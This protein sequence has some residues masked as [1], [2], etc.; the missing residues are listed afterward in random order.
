MLFDISI[1]TDSAFGKY[2]IL[3]G[4]RNDLVVTL[5]TPALPAAAGTTTAN[6]DTAINTAL[7]PFGVNGTNGGQR[8]S[9]L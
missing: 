7:A 4:S 6:I 1:P 5:P 8:L 3:S 9:A 2:N